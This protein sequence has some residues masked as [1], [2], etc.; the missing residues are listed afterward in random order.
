M[1]FYWAGV[2]YGDAWD[3]KPEDENIKQETSD[4]SYQ[5]LTLF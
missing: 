4:E 3:G 1:V 2:D 5:N